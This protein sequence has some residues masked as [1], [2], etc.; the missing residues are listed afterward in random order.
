MNKVDR[1]TLST[2]KGSLIPVKRAEVYKTIVDETIKLNNQTFT[3]SSPS[4]IAMDIGFTKNQ[5]RGTGVE[6]LL[7]KGD[8]TK[9]LSKD[10]IVS[11]Y[12][13][14]LIDK[15]APL[16]DFTNNSIH[17]IRSLDCPGREQVNRWDGCQPGRRYLGFVCSLGQGW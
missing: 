14:H 4:D 1:S 6:D 2:R 7:R 10:E 15:D 3:Y 5:G 12:I 9:L 17:E 16:K 8:V 13:Q 11:N